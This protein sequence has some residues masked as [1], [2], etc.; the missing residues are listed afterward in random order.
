MFL[1]VEW[2]RV[3]GERAAKDGKT[4]SWESPRQELANRESYYL[5]GKDTDK[6]EGN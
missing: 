4:T 1:D 3:Q 5:D 2:S 6:D